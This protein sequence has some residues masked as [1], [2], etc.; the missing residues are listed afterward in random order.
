VWSDPGGCLPWE[1]AFDPR[2]ERFQPL[3]DRRDTQPHR[4][5]DTWS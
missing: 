2:L 5:S 4:W 3:L 1:P